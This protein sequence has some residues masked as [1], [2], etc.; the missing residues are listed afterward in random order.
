MSS[1]PR[2]KVVLATALLTFAIILAA[3]Y[4]VLT[5]WCWTS[6]VLASVP[7]ER[8]L[9]VMSTSEGRSAPIEFVAGRRRID[10][11]WELFSLKG[12]TE[13]RKLPLNSEITTVVFRGLPTYRDMLI[14]YRAVGPSPGVKCMYVLLHRPY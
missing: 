4:V 6:V 11:A 7:A 3:G 5:Y 2:W 14:L 9:E 10:G 1:T 12:R 8:V 13:T